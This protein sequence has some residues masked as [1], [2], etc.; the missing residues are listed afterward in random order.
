M[1]FWMWSFLE[2]CFS[3]IVLSSRF[4][5][6]RIPFK[7]WCEWTEL[8][9]GFF[10]AL[11]GPQFDLRSKL[12]W[13]SNFEGLFLRFYW[14]TEYLAATLMKLD[15]TPS[16]LY[17][18]LFLFFDWGL[19]STEKFFE[20]LCVSKSFFGLIESLGT[21]LIEALRSIKMDEFTWGFW[22]LIDSCWTVLK[23]LSFSDGQADCF[24]RLKGFHFAIGAF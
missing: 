14:F 11:E 21:Q 9:L 13:S 8:D 4:L 10:R 1:F 6:D 17:L 5:D 7:S 3:K 24:G 15:E 22:R 23:F 2:F 18:S 12:E 20:T 16:W 19:G